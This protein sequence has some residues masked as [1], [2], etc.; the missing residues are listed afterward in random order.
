MQAETS[1]LRIQAP[2]IVEDSLPAHDGL[3]R[4]SNQATAAALLYPYVERMVWRLVSRQGMDRPA[5]DRMDV[6]IILKKFVTANAG[7]ISSSDLV[8]WLARDLDLAYG[9]DEAEALLGLSNF[10]SRKEAL[11]QVS[12]RSF[13]VIYPALRASGFEDLSPLNDIMEV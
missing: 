11:L 3:G 8:G 4:A 7:G 1:R 13:V 5:A 2:Q 10:R 12:W 9:R 6:S